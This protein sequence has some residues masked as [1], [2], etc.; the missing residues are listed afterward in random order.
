MVEHEV[1]LAGGGKLQLWDNRRKDIVA[2]R[3]D[4]EVE[5]WE[6]DAADRRRSSTSSRRPNAGSIDSSSSVL[7]AAAGFAR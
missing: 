6:L 3:Q 5:I 7:F 2:Q 4:S 1:A